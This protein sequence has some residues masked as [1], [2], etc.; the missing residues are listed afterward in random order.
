[1]DI[2]EVILQ[3][4]QLARQK[5]FYQNILGLPMVA[6]TNDSITLQAGATLLHFKEVE[7]ESLYHIAF[8]IPRNAFIQAK[9]WVRERIPLLPITKS[10]P[11][12]PADSPLRVQGKKGEDEVYFPVV[13]ARSFYCLDAANNIL[14]FIVYEDLEQEISGP[15]GA[16]SILSVSEIG[17]PAEDVLDVARQLQEQVGLEPY[18]LSR[19]ASRDFAYLG[20]AHGQLVI[21]RTGHAWMPTET[22]LASI[23]PVHLTISGRQEQELQLSPYPYAIRVNSRKN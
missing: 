7:A 17:L 8:A 18:P 9:A 10:L 23:A 13:R 6:E 19:P 4:P 22:V 21:V 16:S 11:V 20:D 1:M 15:F 12:L 3:T 5:V 14:K 2:Q